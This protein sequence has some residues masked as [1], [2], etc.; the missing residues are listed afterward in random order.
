MPD[1]APV[2]SATFP[3]NFS[4]M[5]L[6]PSISVKVVFEILY[7][8]TF[9]RIWQFSIKQRRWLNTKGSQCASLLSP[10]NPA[11]QR[12]QVIQIIHMTQLP[13]ARHLLHLLQN[14]H[15]TLST[16]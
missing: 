7:A 8:I 9:I 15:T 13:Q 5:F 1:E 12:T 3:R 16:L 2:I 10:A 4:A 6:F 11:I 14:S